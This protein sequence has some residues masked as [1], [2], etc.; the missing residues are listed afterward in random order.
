MG[1]CR[2]IVQGSGNT[3]MNKG[4]NLRVSTDKQKETSEMLHA[5]YNKDIRK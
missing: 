5:V 3:E 4:Y 1:T 2:P